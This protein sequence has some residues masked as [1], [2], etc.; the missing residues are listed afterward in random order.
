MERLAIIGSGRMAWIMGKTAKEIGIETYC[1]SNVETPYI[2]ENVNHFVNISIFEKEEIVEICKKN[3]INGVIATTELTVAIASYIAEQL[4]TPGIPYNVSEK[5]TDKYRNRLVCRDLEQLHQPLFYLVNN[6]SELSRVECSYPII[7][8][9]TCEGGKRGITVVN[10]VQELLTAFRFARQFSKQEPIIVEQFI[11]GG[12]EYS[13]ESL[14]FNGKHYIIQV[15]EKISSGPPHCIELGHKQP[16]A[17]SVELRNKIEYAVKE[18]LIAIGIDNTTCHTEIKVVNGEVYLIEFNA[19]PGGDHIAY[20]LT[21]L[22]T[23][24]NIIEGAIKISLN[25]F[26]PINTSLLD[27]NYAGVYFVTQQ[28]EYLKPIFD[29]CENFDW[30]YEKNYVSEELQLLEHN[31]CYNTNSFMYFSRDSEPDL[32]ELITSIPHRE[33]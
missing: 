6:E 33:S 24:Y 13:V 21:K 32:K 15:T 25:K 19:R 27:H 31:D 26:K 10:T 4:H 16:A 30:L 23:G 7:V 18:G 8:K 29:V 14:S 22:S 11:A 28:S 20:P 3:H 12:Q 2:N 1:F 5:I 9:P 17:I